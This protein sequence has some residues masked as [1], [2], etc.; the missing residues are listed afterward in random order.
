VNVSWHWSTGKA[1]SI[2]LMLPAGLWGTCNSTAHLEKRLQKV[3]NV[4]VT[5]VSLLTYQVC[6]HWAH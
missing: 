5:D 4:N 1:R 6:Y 2:F 3:G